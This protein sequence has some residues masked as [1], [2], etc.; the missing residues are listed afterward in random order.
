MTRLPQSLLSLLSPGPW[1]ERLRMPSA[2]GRASAALVACALLAGLGM[3]LTVD[4]LEAAARQRANLEQQTSA[5][6]DRLLIADPAVP[7]LQQVRDEYDRAITR[8]ADLARLSIWGSLALLAGAAL[9][10]GRR[11]PDAGADA[12]PQG[13]AIA[14]FTAGQAGADALGGPADQ[15]G[16]RKLEPAVEGVLAGGPSRRERL[17]DIAREMRALRD[18]ISSE[19]LSDAPAPQHRHQEAA[20]HSVRFHLAA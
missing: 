17:G 16:V 3:T 7:A 18:W 1:A 11:Q 2:R 5:L 9:W 20:V 14:P 6:Q 10:M 12:I 8:A 13:V 4:R 19:P 15:S